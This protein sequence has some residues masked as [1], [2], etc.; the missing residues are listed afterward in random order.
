MDELKQYFEILGLQPGCSLKKIKEA[1]RSMVKTW[2]PDQ[3]DSYPNLK[4]IGQNKMKEI[5]EAYE[6][7]ILIYFWGK[8][9][10][11]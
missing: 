4:V 11:H 7:L 6:K 2:H 10:S 3:Y 1:Y 8:R 9:K 5:N